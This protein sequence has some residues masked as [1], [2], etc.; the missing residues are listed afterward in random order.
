MPI[1]FGIPEIPLTT[2]FATFFSI[3]TII[4]LKKYKLFD[5]SPISVSQQILDTMNDGL[6]ISDK[7]GKIQ[8]A[9]NALCNMLNYKCSELYAKPSYYFITAGE[10]EKVA[11]EVKSR[12]KGTVGQYETK[13]RTKEGKI[14]NVLISGSPFYTN[15][16]RIN[17]SLA[18]ITDITSIKNQRKMVLSAMLDGEER[19]RKRLAQELHDGIAQY[20]TAINLNLSTFD[21][22]IA[23]EHHETLQILKKITRDTIIETRSLSHNL[24]PK[25]IEQELNISLQHLVAGFKSVSSIKIEIQ[26]KGKVFTLSLS[27]KF[28]LYRISQE[29]INNSIKHSKAKKIELFLNFN[30]NN[31]ELKLSDNGIGFDINNPKMKNGIGLINI[32]QRTEA[33]DGILKFNSVKGFGTELK[34]IVPF[35]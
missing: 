34:I 23:P 16:D 13:M 7:K 33:I 30:S 21:D 5:Y 26:I 29:F 20:L 28:N 25:G 8:Y 17:G 15:N 1:F 3:A 35:L 24:I 2:T 19:E 14:L 22:H 12:F 4:A 6:L 32:K 27:E 11:E 10:R 31:I 18:I 9:N